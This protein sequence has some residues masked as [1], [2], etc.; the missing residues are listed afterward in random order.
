MFK[1]GLRYIGIIL[2]SLI[3]ALGLRYGVVT[4]GNIP[5]ESMVPTLNVGD[6]VI[7]FRT[8]LVKPTRGD[9]VVFSPNPEQGDEYQLW[10][11]RLIGLPGD[12]VQIKKGKVYINGKYLEEPYVK[13]NLDYTRTF[14]VPEDRYFVLG[15]NRGNS[16]DSRFWGNSFLHIEQAKY[17]CKMKIFPLSD[18]EYYE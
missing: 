14:I 10:I 8:Y 11:K 16:L 1:N 13:N 2:L 9:I 6:K 17:T 12:K 18:I 4:V 15:D 3:L 7:A 5:S